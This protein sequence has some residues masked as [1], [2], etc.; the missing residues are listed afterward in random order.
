[1]IILLPVLL[2]IYFV[3]RKGINLYR[4]LRFPYIYLSNHRDII[5]T[6]HYDSSSEISRH[7]N[8]VVYVNTSTR[9]ILTFEHD[10]HMPAETLEIFIKDLTKR[11]YPS[12]KS[13]FMIYNGKTN[14][15]K[16]ASWKNFVGNVGL[17]CEYLRG[18]LDIQ[19]GFD[20][21]KER[22]VIFHIYR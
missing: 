18:K 5:T 15:D 9:F 19:I 21:E 4:N 1:M 16:I 7:I 20:Q 3:I 8:Y 17:S 6:S 10:H 2:C 11:L 13:R 12:L 14:Q 22:R